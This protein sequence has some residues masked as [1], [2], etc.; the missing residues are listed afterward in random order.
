MQKILQSYRFH[1]TQKSMHSVYGALP[2]MY[3]NHPLPEPTTTMGP[4]IV[5]AQLHRGDP[6]EGNATA[7]TTDRSGR[8]VSAERWGAP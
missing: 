6:P 3:D 8:R 2:Q 7:R 5:V 1:V 4:S